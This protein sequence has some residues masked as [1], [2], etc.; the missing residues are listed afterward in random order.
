MG[1]FQ[2]L[3]CTFI[4]RLPRPIFVRAARIHGSNVTGLSISNVCRC[5]VGSLETTSV[6]SRAPVPLKLRNVRRASAKWLRSHPAVR[7]SAAFYPPSSSGVFPHHGTKSRY[8][9][10]GKEK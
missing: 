7:K 6:A 2:E 4:G 3:P 5:G 1:N 8:P 9:N 10:S